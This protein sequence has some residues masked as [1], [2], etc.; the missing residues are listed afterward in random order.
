MLYTVDTLERAS[1][2]YD[3]RLA[4]PRGVLCDIYVAAHRLFWLDTKRPGDEPVGASQLS[5]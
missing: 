4:L 3:Q 2:T 5:H 1:R